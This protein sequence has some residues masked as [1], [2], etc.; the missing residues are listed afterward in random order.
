MNYAL[1]QRN[2]AAAILE[3]RRRAA[4]NKPV[5]DLPALRP[6]QQAMLDH[7]ARFKI[8]ACG[9][10]YGKT[11][12]DIRILTEHALQGEKLGFFSMT[13]RNLKN[14]YRELKDVLAS[15]TRRFSEAEIIELT[16]GGVIEFWSLQ[17]ANKDTARGRKYDGVVIDEAAFIP[18][19]EYVW[20]GVIRPTI[21][22]TQGFA[23][24]SSST[25]GRNQ[26][27]KW[28]QYGLDPTNT[29]WKSF[30][31]P[32]S[33]NPDMTAEELESIRRE[34]PDLYFRQEYLAEFLENEGAVFR[35][36][37]EN[38]IL[39]ALTST[40][41][42]IAIE[43]IMEHRYVFG[44]DWAM[45]NDFTVISVMDKETGQQVA[46]DRFNQVDW[47]LQRGRLT[48]LAAKYQPE[49]IYAESNSI[50][51]PNIE[52]LQRD[53]LPVQGF[54]TTGTSKPMLIENLVLAFEQDEIKVLNDDILKGELM[55]YERTV[56]AHTGRSQYS[57]PDGMHDDMVIAL[58]LALWACVNVGYITMETASAEIRSAFED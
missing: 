58:A 43:P 1:S 51:N 47:A 49:V 29:E 15:H 45:K 26:F 56:S 48:A 12:V 5:L 52:A 42:R 39:E 36:I 23:V 34:T 38:A 11:V 40:Y 3:L 10:R 50:G 30:H 44:V 53:G 14:V 19:T 25:N 22:D 4:V 7:P 6:D 31:H 54:E 2:K 16:N 13:Y 41:P 9:R 8:L 20:N 55:A 21:A 33:D 35:R 18:N 46:M 32:S 27:F 37:G 28:Y 24:L 17:T 57:A